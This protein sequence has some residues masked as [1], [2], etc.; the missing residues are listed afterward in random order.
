M[1]LRDRLLFFSLDIEDICTANK[2]CVQ[3]ES[4]IDG[5]INYTFLMLH[6]H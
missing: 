2:N 1:C 4:A 6:R 3:I 5:V